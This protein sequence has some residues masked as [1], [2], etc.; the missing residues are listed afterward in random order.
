[1]STGALLACRTAPNCFLSDKSPAGRAR[2][3]SFARLMRRRMH[4]R[5]ED[6]KTW[7]IWQ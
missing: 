6:Q 2:R 5:A 3:V 4:Y 7:I 1:M